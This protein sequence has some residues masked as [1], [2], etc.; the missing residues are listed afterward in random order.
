MRGAG[1]AS[2]ATRRERPL[3]RGDVVATGAQ[4]GE[5]LFQESLAL[6]VGAAFL[7]VREV[8]LVRLVADGL[9]RV[10][11]VQSGGKPA[12]RAVPLHGDLAVL[13]DGEGR[14]RD[15]PLDAV[16]REDLAR[17]ALSALSLA[18]GPGPYARAPNRVATCHSYP[19]ASL[20]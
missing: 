5:R 7:H 17:R 13:A 14:L 6:L 20:R 12:T 10:V 15:V 2:E 16:V 9:R 1:P 11:R 3:F 4:G 8:R 19:P 18:H